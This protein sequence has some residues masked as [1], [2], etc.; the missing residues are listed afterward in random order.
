MRKLNFFTKYNPSLPNVDTLVK[1]Y[2]P[3]LHS[4]ENFKELFPASPFN[5]TYRHNKNLKKLLSPSLYP[6]RKSTKSNSIISCNSC[7]ICKNYMV[8]ENMFT[9]TV[10]GKKYF[11]KGELHCN[12][13]NV[14]Y[15]VEYSNCKQQY[16]G[17][18]LN[19]NQGF[20]IHKSHIKTNKDCCGTARHFSN[21]CCHPSNP[22][23]YSKV[24]LIELVFCNDTDEDIEAILW[25]REKCWQS[26]LFTNVCGM[27][28]VSDLYSRKR[29]GCE[30]K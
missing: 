5:T 30:R 17:S 24:R 11:V 7:D 14:I 21:V 20:M 19:F 3:D 29:K 2:L 12:S 1:K 9:C 13:C 4:D 16:I 10:T 26:Q 22:H 6:N 18:A 27:N 8:S 28:S 25:E 15:L 23:F